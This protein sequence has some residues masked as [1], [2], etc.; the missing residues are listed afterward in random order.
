[1]G[2][3]RQTCLGAEV[4]M[5][6]EH[7]LRKKKILEEEC[8]QQTNLLKEKDAEIVILKSQLSLKEAEAVKAIRL[9]GHVATVKATEALH[10][11]ELNLLKERNSTL[12][13][14]MR[15]FEEKVA[16]LESKKSGLTD[17]VSSLEAACAELH[18]QVSSYENFKEQIEAVQDEQVRVLTEKIKMLT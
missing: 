15:A 12:E 10:A 4:R 18:N 17:Q 7:T 11:A 3:A 16:V 5:R 2:V 14:K 6:T 13:A 8:A 9:R 1:M